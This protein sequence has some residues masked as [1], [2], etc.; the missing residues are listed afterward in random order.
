MIAVVEGVVTALIVRAL[1]AVRPDLVR[2]A[3]A[4]PA[5]GGATARCGRGGRAMSGRV[6]FVGAGPGAADLLTL[7]AA[8]V[9]GEADVVVW[10]R[11]LVDPGGARARPARRRARSPP[12]T[13]R[14]TTCVAIYARAAAEGLRVARVHSG[15]PTLY[16]TLHEQLGACRALGLEVEIVPGVSARWRPPRPR[17]GRS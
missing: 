15:D 13:R 2:V 9:L 4:A 8:R 5:P 11:C 12:T 10:A 6:S 1:L 17:S 3:D 7:R 16:G 14:S